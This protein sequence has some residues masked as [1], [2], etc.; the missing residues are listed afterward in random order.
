MW[1]ALANQYVSLR[2]VMRPQG[3]SAVVTRRDQT[4][5]VLYEAGSHRVKLTLTTHVSERVPGGN[6]STGKLF[7]GGPRQSARHQVATKSITRWTSVCPTDRIDNSQFCTLVLPVTL[8][9]VM[10]ASGHQARY[11]WAS[12]C[13]NTVT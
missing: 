1:T 6:K 4:S 10:S 3:P 9:P 5:H 2:L 11:T 7:D 13:A 8:R 12:L